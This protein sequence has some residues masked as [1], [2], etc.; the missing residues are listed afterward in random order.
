MIVGGGGPNSAGRGVGRVA[1][2]PAGSASTRR[3]PCARPTGCAPRACSCRSTGGA[4]SRRAARSWRSCAGSRHR[5][6]DLDRRGVPRRHRLARPVRRG[7]GDRPP[8]QGRQCATRWA[9]RPRS[10]VATTKLVAK[11]ASDLR[12]PDGL[13]VVPPGEE[14]AFLAP[15]PISR[16]WGVGERRR[17]A[18]RD[19]GV[20]TIGDLAALPPR[21]A[22][23]AVRQAWRR[24]WS[25]ARMGL[26]PD[27]V[28]TGDPAKS[29]GHEH[30]FD[31]DTRRSRGHRADAAGH[32]R[33]RGLAASRAG[34]KAGTVTLKLRDS[35]FRTI[36]RQ[37]TLDDPDRPD[38]ADLRGRPGPAPP[39]AP[40]PAD[41]AGGRDGI[42]LPRPGAARPVRRRPTRGA[43]RRPRRWTASGAS[44]GSGR[45]PAAGSCAP[46]CR[47]R[48][49]ATR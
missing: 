19:F 3:C 38:R 31:V 23:A 12:K 14:A 36:T 6:A 37:T 20:V 32:G 34:L 33:R 44:T 40:R 27:P 1:T 13:V 8:D 18:L 48:S 28:A 45:S 11:I 30:T 21:R 49:S 29:I 26:D 15:L 5:S 16:L 7:R 22:R 4:T 17:A 41:P 24:R 42:E 39:R 2:R 10:G 35:T 9:S 25:T 47:P 46:A 43:S